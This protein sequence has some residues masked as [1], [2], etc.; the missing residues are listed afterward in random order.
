MM[1]LAIL[2]YLDCSSWGGA[3]YVDLVLLCDEGI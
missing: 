1:V 2:A 3:E